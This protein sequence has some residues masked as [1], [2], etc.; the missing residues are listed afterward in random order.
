MKRDPLSQNAKK[1]EKF[2]TKEVFKLISHY[3]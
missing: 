1:K 2:Q 3:N